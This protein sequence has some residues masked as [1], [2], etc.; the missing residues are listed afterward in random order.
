MTLW[1]KTYLQ[2]NYLSIENYQLFWMYTKEKYYESLGSELQIKKNRVRNLIG[3]NGWLEDGRYK[4]VILVNLISRFL[5][6]NYSIGTGYVISTVEKGVN[7]RT[8]QIDI[9]IYDNSFPIFFKEGDFVILP[10]DSVRGIIEVKSKIW[11]RRLQDFEDAF[12][13]MHKNANFI[14]DHMKDHSQKNKEFFN[15]MFFYERDPKLS[16]EDVMNLIE[17]FYVGKKMK[18]D[19]FPNKICID[20]DYIAVA[21]SNKYRCYKVDDKATFL[22]IS[23][24][25]NSLDIKTDNTFWN[26]YKEIGQYEKCSF[27]L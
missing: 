1:F 15:G 8:N 7:G 23:L 5:P 2:N 21:F 17:R 22:F 13:K 14:K 25:F 11:K 16:P 12:E 3:K 6:K 18:R 24:L 9:I 10:P 27:S 20:N 19:F 4:E 26:E